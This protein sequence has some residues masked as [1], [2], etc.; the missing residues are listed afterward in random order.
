[1]FEKFSL[2]LAAMSGLLAVVPIAFVLLHCSSEDVVFPDGTGGAT[3]TSSSLSLGVGA[4]SSSTSASMRASGGAGGTGNAAGGGGPCVPT[5]CENNKVYACANCIDDDGDQKIDA[6]DENCLGPCD[7]SE[8][9]LDLGIPGA[10]NAP[11]KR[12]CYFDKDGGAGNDDCKHDLRCDP[13][14]PEPINCLYSN[15]PPSNADCPAK[16][17][18]TCQKICAPLTPNGCDCFGCCDVPGGSN[19]FVFIGSKDASDV[20]TCTVADAKDPAKCH[21]CTPFGECF[22]PCGVCELC[23]GKTTL[24]PECTPADQ[25]ADGTPCGLD[26]QA[27]CPFGEYCITGCCQPPNPT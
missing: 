14:S 15:P 9:G 1:M 23:L 16:Q 7:N 13:L 26:G 12:D 8:D 3:G 6:A 22:N 19:N 4:G 25:C 20:P 11:C 24:P 21:P 17:S 5:A 27:P 10:G 18:D 2:R